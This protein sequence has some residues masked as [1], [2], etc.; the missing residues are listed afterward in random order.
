MVHAL[1]DIWRVLKNDAVLIDLRPIPTAQSIDILRGNEL[2]ES[3]HF[4]DSY[5]IEND[6]AAN[7]A[8]ATVRDTHFRLEH[9]H[10]F[11]FKKIFDNL[12]ELI[13]EGQS[14]SPP[15]TLNQASMQPLRLASKQY[16]IRFQHRY[17]MLLNRYRKIGE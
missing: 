7:S 2:I 5:R 13:E 9:S 6:K 12:D 4:D 14:K 8:I 17:D 1:K 16:D 10:P 15:I 11:P 3:Y